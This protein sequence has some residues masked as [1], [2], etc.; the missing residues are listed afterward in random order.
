[1]LNLFFGKNKPLPKSKVP[2]LL[3]PNNA[4]GSPS[5]EELRLPPR[6][7]LKP[8]E[9]EMVD[10]VMR[11]FK[12]SA[13]SKTILERDWLTDMA[14]RR[15]NPWSEVHQES[16]DLQSII[17]E[18]D[19]YRTYFPGNFIDPPLTKLKSKATSS[20]P[21]ASTKPLT[22]RPQDVGAA[23]EGRDILNHYD[24]LLDRQSQTNDWVD[25][26]LEVSTT[27]LKPFW[28][29]LKFALTSYVEDDPNGANAPVPQAQPA[30]GDAQG[31]SPQAPIDF[32]AL[33]PKLKGNV[34]VKS[35]QIG[36]IE[37]IVVP[38]FEVYPD[39]DA[40]TWADA[41]WL[42]HAKSR[43][44]EYIREHYGE[45]GW[46]VLGDNPDSSAARWET[47]V[48]AITGDPV[49]T[50]LGPSTRTNTVYEYWEIPT[51]RY[52][53]GRLLRVAGGYLL[54]DPE[55]STQEDIDAWQ[56][57]NPDTEMRDYP[58][59]DCD[60]PYEKNDE[61]PFIPLGY[62]DRWGTI[63]SEGAVRGVTGH[64]K[65]IDNTISRITDSINMWK[66]T[67]LVPNGSN[68]KVDDY[69]SRRSYNIVPYEPGMP[70]TIISPGPFPQE[71]FT[72]ITMLKGFIEDT[73][74]MHDASNG[75]TP[76]GVTAGVALETLKESDESLHRPFFDNIEKAHKKRA[77]WEIALCAQFYNEPRLVG[78]SQDGDN[79]TALMN[80]KSFDHLTSGGKCRVE[81]VPGS[82]IPKSPDAQ[83]QKWL[84]LLKS[85][86]FTPQMFPM[87]KAVFDQIGLEKS[88]VMPQRIDQ[89]MLEV[90]ALQKA[91]Q[92]DPALAQAA[93][94]A[95]QEAADNAKLKMAM[96][97]ADA[98]VRGDIAVATVKGQMDAQAADKEL[99]A[100]E[101]ERAF[102]TRSIMEQTS[103]Q[104]EL[105]A[106]Q[107]IVEATYPKTSI[108]VKA[109]PE[110]TLGAEV[111]AH[112]PHLDDPED[113]R[114]MAMKPTADTK[115][116]ST[117]G[118]K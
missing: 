6:P 65:V 11:C 113:L 64:Q 98:K 116:P 1:M 61:F 75:I 45:R 81:V 12:R 72:L 29:P 58:R 8:S 108:A 9:Q 82:A 78:I 89:A 103:H 93:Q 22:P 96:E 86:G 43:N 68:I 13:D 53:L 19:P 100:R 41:L 105:T 74:G 69:Q 79:D 106:Q 76:P 114:K 32:N 27:F 84:D 17:D 73:L 83:S 95:T 33:L 50:N 118:S 20:R 5:P 34:V 117:G 37:E 25:G 80:A 70:P 36:D 110:G 35:A 92:P 2:E 38:P 28:D 3:N 24:N 46:Y 40:R 107:H 56:A 26:S 66:Q 104:A 97:L 39:P 87:L 10:E 44:L 111:L 112:Y 7:P 90:I 77:E 99:A 63:W 42:I 51:M 52:P 109:G 47:R 94:A 49:R 14:Q 57:A 102:E 18:D 101:Q 88:D 54:S 67:I 23:A 31:Q 16:G 60:W 55:V 62:R 48:D 115:K 21:D 15:G 4:K 59:K 71:G 91:L 30:Q 85:G